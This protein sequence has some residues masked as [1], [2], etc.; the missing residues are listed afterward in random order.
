MKGTFIMV[1]D[2][3][4]SVC[5]GYV[6]WES[7]WLYGNTHRLKLKTC[8][9]RTDGG[10]AVSLFGYIYINGEQ[11]V[12]L[13]VQN[14]PGDESFPVQTIDVET[15]DYGYMIS[16]VL[17]SIGFYSQAAGGSLWANADFTG[18]YIGPPVKSLNIETPDGIVCS[19]DKA[20]LHV[21]E[22]IVISVTLTGIQWENYTL[23][24]T[25][26]TKVSEYT[27]TIDG[28]VYIVVTGVLARHTIYIN[29]KSGMNIT[30]I[31][32]ITGEH[33]IDGSKVEHYS[34][35]TI[36]C[37]AEVGYELES[38]TVN[39]EIYSSSVSIEVTSDIIISIAGK[40]L[41]AVYIYTGNGFELF[42]VYIYDGVSWNMMIPYVYNGL[43][44]S[45]CV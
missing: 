38:I 19:V 1:P 13:G 42:H 45:M 7:T 16:S 24:V 36:S 37:V 10:P 20:E 35:I 39:G 12:N 18:Y 26:A 2:P 34:S 40:P 44:W 32:D 43:E 11:S 23:S 14:Y 15:D 31:D 3:P 22:E 8:G 29:S 17:V 28:D 30:I 9:Y 6:E 4:G 41:G 5:E 27:Y 33:Y 25:G 21:G